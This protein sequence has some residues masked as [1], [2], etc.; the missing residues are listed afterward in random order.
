MQTSPS[1][2]R[3]ESQEAEDLPSSAEPRQRDA[4]RQ[5]QGP[6]PALYLHSLP[7]WARPTLWA[8][9]RKTALAHKI[10]Q[11]DERKADSKH[12]E[13]FSMLSSFS[14]FF[15]LSGLQRNF[16]SPLENSETI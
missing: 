9:A 3:A 16:F 11:M 1:Q 13:K 6:C 15:W 12:K 14:I 7:P 8:E 2:E 4:L 5:A 10:V